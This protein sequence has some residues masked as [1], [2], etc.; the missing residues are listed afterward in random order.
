[1]YVMYV[2]LMYILLGCYDSQS[3]QQSYARLQDNTVI[4]TKPCQTCFCS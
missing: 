4:L 1:M 2:Y 3:G